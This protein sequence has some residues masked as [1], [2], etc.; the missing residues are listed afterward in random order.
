M[1]R[2]KGS[3]PAIITPMKDGTVDEEALSR[4]TEWLMAETSDGIVACGTTGEGATLKPEETV[5]VVRTVK[6]VVGDSAPVIAGTGSNDTGKTVELTKMA[7]EAGADAA[8]VVTPYYNKP[9]PEGLFRHY[10][11]VARDG[12]L[13]VIMYNVPGRTALSMSLDSVCRCASIDGVVGIKDASRDMALAVS[14]RERCGEDFNLLSGDD[15]TILPFLACGGDG[16]ITVVGNVAPRDTA[17]LIRAFNAGELDRARQMQAKL[18]PLIDALFAESSPVPLK[19]AMSMM[20]RCE[21]SLR[22]PLTPASEQTR[23]LLREVM[24]SYGGLLE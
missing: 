6:K 20:G 24:F 22:M 7:R 15:F 5:V 9:T 13:P 23:A 4:L 2:L 12:G 21:D 18:L 8:L 3:Y 11:V 19:A 17:E 10:E 14:I 1:R 16:V